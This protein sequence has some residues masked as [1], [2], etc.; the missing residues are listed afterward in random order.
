[1][2]LSSE[3]TWPHAVELAKMLFGKGLIATQFTDFRDNDS[4]MV[5]AS[6]VSDSRET[7]TQEFE[8]ER[9]LLLG[10]LRSC[11]GCTVVYFSSCSICE[12]GIRESPYAQHKLAMEDIIRREA[13]SFLICRL[14]QVVGRGGNPNTLMNY[15]VGA[16]K[17]GDVIE[18][19][20]GVTR[21]FIDVEHVSQIVRKILENSRGRQLRNTINIASPYSYAVEDVVNMIARHLC[22][23]IECNLVDKGAPFEIDINAMQAYY[24]GGGFN[25]GDDYLQR[26][27]DRYY[28]ADSIV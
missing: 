24:G 18:V 13:D 20:S 2:K 15:L 12:P 16:A 27:L 22:L 14:S 3:I 5:F 11:R 19:W 10:G 28:P 17:N 7:R 25:F 26:L 4:I 21:N 9:S 6:G 23:S 1:M 8:R